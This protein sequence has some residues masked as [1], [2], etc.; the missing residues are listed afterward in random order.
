MYQT[1]CKQAKVED[2]LACK[3]PN[4]ILRRYAVCHNNPK[5][6]PRYRK[7]PIITIR[8]GKV[9]DNDQKSYNNSSKENDPIDYNNPYVQCYTCPE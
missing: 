4:S 9:A 6:K 2:L 1:G 5:K 8:V 3:N 7:E